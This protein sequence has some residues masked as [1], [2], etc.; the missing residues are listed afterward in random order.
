[1]T[2][3]AVLV[4]AALL[5]ALDIRL[6][7]LN[8]EERALLAQ[9]QPAVLAAGC[10]PVERIPPYPDGLDRVHIG[11][12]EAPSMPP[13]SSYPSVPPASGPHDP[14][15]LGAGVYAR[16]PVIARAIHSLEHAAVIVWYEPSVPTSTLSG[17]MSFFARH[18][19]SN[20][21]IVA[22]YD[23]PEA[24]E[25]GRL[26]A[27]RQMALVAWHHVRYCDLVSLPVAFDFVHG[28]RFNLY[29][30][31]AYRGDAPEKFAPI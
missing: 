10:S 4:A 29:Q 15:P 16:P 24:G 30:W 28:Y 21:V 17:T 19:E 12:T 23:Y 20:H 5:V 2:V 14:V 31:G 26:P 22:P 11:A 18:D 3:G 1:V 8:S 6:H 7:R 25:A 9:A 27:G 13:L